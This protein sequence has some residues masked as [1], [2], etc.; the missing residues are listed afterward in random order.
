MLINHRQ[1]FNKNRV[2][3]SIERG[4]LDD[5]SGLFDRS[6]DKMLNSR[7]GINEERDRERIRGLEREC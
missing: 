5:Y 2:V 7:A 3:H 6:L 4:T 1:L